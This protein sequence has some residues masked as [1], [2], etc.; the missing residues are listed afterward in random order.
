VHIK[1]FCFP[2]DKPSVNHRAKEKCKR[3]EVE[4]GRHR[5]RFNT[6][7]QLKLDLPAPTPKEKMTDSDL[8]FLDKLKSLFQPPIKLSLEYRR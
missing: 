3:K 4:T 7:W 1:Q 8:A 5:S 6:Q 2:N